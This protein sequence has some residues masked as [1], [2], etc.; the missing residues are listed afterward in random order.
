MVDYKRTVLQD[1]DPL[2]Q[3]LKS[4]RRIL[5]DF[6]AIVYYQR[7]A[8][9]LSFGITYP[10][11][12]AR[13][14]APAGLPKKIGIMRMHKNYLNLFNFHAR[15]TI[16]PVFL[17][18]SSRYAGLCMWLDKLHRSGNS[19]HIVDEYKNHWYPPCFQKRVDTCPKIPPP[20]LLRL[21]T[22]T[23]D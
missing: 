18:K 16:V 5:F 21:L 22:D 1:P 17:T 12:A 19:R 23:S 14:T 7:C 9:Y 11:Q 2:F 13:N 20:S 10:P 15:R 8:V 4:L 3:Q 6:A